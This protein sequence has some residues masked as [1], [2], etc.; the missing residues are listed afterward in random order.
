MNPEDLRTCLDRRFQLDGDGY[1]WRSTVGKFAVSVVPWRTSADTDC[2]RVTVFDCLTNLEI[3][4]WTHSVRCTDN[5]RERLQEL[6]GKA[7]I[8]AQHRPMCTNCTESEGEMVPMVV[9]TSAKH[10]SQFFGCINYRDTHCRHTARI[11]TRSEPDKIPKSK[12]E[13]SYQKA[14]P[15]IH[16]LRVHKRFCRVPLTNSC[17]SLGNFRNFSSAQYCS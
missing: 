3:D 4:E 16:G 5:W 9:R 2:L 14:R 17:F 8:R 13:D 12:C 1:I 15:S 11:R 6:V 10:K 7:M